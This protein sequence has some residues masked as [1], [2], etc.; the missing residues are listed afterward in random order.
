VVVV[1]SRLP[2]GAIDRWGEI[3]DAL[4]L[5]RSLKAR[6]DPNGILSPGRGPGGL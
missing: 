2:A 5:M 6:F 4:P 1:D 3:G